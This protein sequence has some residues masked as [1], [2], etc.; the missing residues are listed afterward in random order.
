MTALH[1]CHWSGAECFL[2]N[3]DVGSVSD[4]RASLLGGISAGTDQDEE[5]EKI[6]DEDDDKV[7]CTFEQGE[8]KQ[9]RRGEE[10]KKSQPVFLSAATSTGQTSWKATSVL[11]ERH[12]YE[13]AVAAKWLQR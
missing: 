2:L 1:A 3:T 6:A 4:A 13:A 11:L 7:F 10:K 12:R 9:R 8:L 5:D